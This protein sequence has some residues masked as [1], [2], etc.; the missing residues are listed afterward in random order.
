MT[1]AYCPH[2]S[3]CTREA[4]GHSLIPS[5]LHV[6][7]ANPCTDLLP[8]ISLQLGQID[9]KL[10][11]RAQAPRTQLV[12]R[13][14]PSIP[15]DCSWLCPCFQPDAARRLLRRRNLTLTVRPQ[16]ELGCSWGR[17]EQS[18]ARCLEMA[19]YRQEHVGEE[20]PST[21]LCLLGRDHTDAS[22]SSSSQ[23][24]DAWREEH[25]FSIHPQTG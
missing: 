22:P 11:S 5:R 18:D 23:P 6:Q 19:S 10:S 4:A 1:S 13:S 7:E 16:Q 2:V 8:P 15:G 21:G 9:R 17:A 14:Q 25:R 20:L 3:V 24:Q 12:C